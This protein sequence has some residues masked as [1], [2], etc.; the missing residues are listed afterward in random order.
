MATRML[1]E[2]ERAAARAE[3]AAGLREALGK[4]VG[5][6]VAERVSA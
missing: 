6:L 3:N 5:E 2:A 4:R 1:V